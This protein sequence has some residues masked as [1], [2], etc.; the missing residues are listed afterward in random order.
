MRAYEWSAWLCERYVSQFK[1]TRKQIKDSEES[2]VFVGFP[3]T[4]LQKYTIEGCEVVQVSEKEFVMNLPDGILPND[5]TTESLTVDFDNWKHSVPLSEGKRGK[6]NNQVP[7]ILNSNPSP[8]IFEILQRIMSFPLESNS[9]IDCMLFLGEIKQQVARIYGRKIVNAGRLS[10]KCRRIPS[11]I[12]IRRQPLPLL[13]V[14][15]RYRVS[16]Q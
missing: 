12:S 5:S 9:P 16:E 4:S 2:F 10:G 13:F 8:R 6:T 14:S 11:L 15:S 7:N 3:Q 1:A